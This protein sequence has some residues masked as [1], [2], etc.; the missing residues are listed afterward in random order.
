MKRVL[1]FAVFVLSFM[2]PVSLHA[3]PIFINEIHYD[4]GGGDIR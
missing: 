2:L 4:N 1:L 3:T